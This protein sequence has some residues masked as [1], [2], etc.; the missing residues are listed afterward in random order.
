MFWVGIG[1]LVVFLVYF[2]Y[3]INKANDSDPVWSHLVYV[4]GGIEAITFSIIGAFFGTTVQ[5]SQTE[6]ANKRAATAEGQAQENRDEAEIAQATMSLIET[7]L[8]DLGF[9]AGSPTGAAATN[10]GADG[11]EFE[12][13]QIGAAATHLPESTP[14][15]DV[16]NEIVS[17]Q[18]DLRRRKG[19]A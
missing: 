6:A 8:R 15:S 18:R 16:L 10:E 3:L 4:Y 7:K 19:L 17:F 9:P 14:E 12:E 2:G 11:E 5:R 13:E 1:F